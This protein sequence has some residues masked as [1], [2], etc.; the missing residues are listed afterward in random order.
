MKNHRLLIR[1]SLLGAATFLAAGTALLRGADAPP[2]PPALVSPD[3]PLAEL[4][5]RDATLRDALTLIG[6]PAGLNLAASDEAAKT[7]VTIHLHN[8]TP[9]GAVQAICQTNGLFFKKPSPEEIGIVTT[10]KEFQDGITIFREEKTK[11]Y[12]LLYPN[13]VDLAGPSATFSGRAYA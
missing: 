7:K 5:L 6:A 2:G 9:F 8:I 12:T 1:S 10:V 3:T 4:D 13:A 11:I